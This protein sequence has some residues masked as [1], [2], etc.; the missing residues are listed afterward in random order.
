MWARASL[1]RRF[2]DTNV[3]GTGCVKI[4]WKT[5]HKISADVRIFFYSVYCV[6][7]SVCIAPSSSLI[8]ARRNVFVL[9]R[10]PSS[11]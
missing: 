6:F 3:Y 9:D 5:R 11:N 4:I 7:G 1:F 8:G 10:P 2:A